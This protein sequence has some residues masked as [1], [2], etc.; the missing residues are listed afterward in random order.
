MARLLKS[1]HELF[2]CESD[3]GYTKITTLACSYH[4]Y[5]AVNQIGVQLHTFSFKVHHATEIVFLFISTYDEIIRSVN[6][7]L[8]RS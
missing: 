7:A 6:R 5:V 8:N 1:Y 4:P 2:T 3:T